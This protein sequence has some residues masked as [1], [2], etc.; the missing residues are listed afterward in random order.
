MTY[1]NLFLPG[2][3][4][5]V[6][7]AKSTCFDT[8][9][10]GSGLFMERIQVGYSW[11]G[12]L[13]T[14]RGCTIENPERFAGENPGVFTEGSCFLEWIADS[15]GL[16]LGKGYHT[17]CRSK[18]G[19]RLDVDK[20]DCVAANGKKCRFNTGIAF[21]VDKK[22]Q[23]KSTGLFSIE[24]NSG[25]PFNQC[26]LNGQNRI[27]I[28]M[29]YWCLAF[30]E[31][32]DQIDLDSPD[33]FSTCANNCPGVRAA[34][35]V[36]GGAAAFVAV[37]LAGSSFLTPIAPILPALGAVGLGVFGIGAGGLAR[38]M[39]AGPLFCTTS[40]GTCCLLVFSQNGLICPDGC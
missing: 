15:Y 40:L 14:Y 8:G 25:V 33:I 24:K 17:G 21:N 20:S 34:D 18:S 37:A 23:Q 12:A 11:E 2:T 3:I 19:E 22:N 1:F 6:D 30:D 32:I 39:C 13:S 26:I 36:A 5:G 10:S 9:D 7:P 16:Q 38:E 27:G 31:N 4:C 28:H 29:T 35:I